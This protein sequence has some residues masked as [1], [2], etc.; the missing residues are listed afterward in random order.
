MDLISD[1]FC[2]GSHN[3]SSLLLSH[4][5]LGKREKEKA[6]KTGEREEELR[7]HAQRD[8]ALA[9]RLLLLVK[10]QVQEQISLLL[11]YPSYCNICKQ[12]R[13]VYYPVLV[14]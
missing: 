2:F 7:R 6:K 3:L 5:P 11:V 1:I 10:V 9:L 14:L 13:G 8:D 12:E 4:A